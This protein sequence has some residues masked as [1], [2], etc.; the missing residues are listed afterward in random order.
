MNDEGKGN[1]RA[2]KGEHSHGGPWEREKEK[3]KDEHSIINI[4][5][6]TFK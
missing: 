1:C 3:G 5:H 2:V 6:P 4:Q